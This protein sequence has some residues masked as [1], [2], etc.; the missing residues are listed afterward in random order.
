MTDMTLRSPTMK[1]YLFYIGFAL[2]IVV[3]IWLAHLSY[4]RIVQPSSPY[5]VVDPSVPSINNPLGYE[6]VEITGLDPKFGKQ[7]MV[8]C[9][10]PVGYTEYIHYPPNWQNNVLN[11]KSW[12]GQTTKYVLY[13][14][15]GLV[16][17]F[18]SWRIVRI[19]RLRRSK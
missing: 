1:R 16:L 14:I 6:P 7:M 3:G 18:M 17:A 4:T 15:L 19:V 9:K 10:M 8:T 12:Q 11:P 13:G 5:M 2:A